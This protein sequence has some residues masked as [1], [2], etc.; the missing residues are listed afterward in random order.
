VEFLS[1]ASSYRILIPKDTTGFTIQNCKIQKEELGA[2]ASK[3]MCLTAD[4]VEKVVLSVLTENNVKLNLGVNF[5]AELKPTGKYA[6]IIDLE[7]GVIRAR[8]VTNEFA[9]RL[10]IKQKI[11]KVFE[12][13][14]KIGRSLHQRAIDIRGETSSNETENFAKAYIE[15][16][17]KLSAEIDRLTFLTTED[18]KK[19][20]VSCF[21]QT[22]LSYPEIKVPQTAE[23][24]FCD[25]V[26]VAF[27]SLPDEKV[28]QSF[29]QKK[30]QLEEI[31]TQLKA[32]KS[33]EEM[34]KTGYL[35]AQVAPLSTYLRALAK[36]L[37]KR[38]ISFKERSIGLAA[39]R[40]Q[41]YSEIIIEIFD[42]VFNPNK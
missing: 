31:Q 42:A 16:S 38:N 41:Q 32:I 23:M 25:L 4:K 8:F 15:T 9:A 40:L 30:K 24:V 28:R 19:E 5:Q 6:I 3:G 11:L 22:F 20:I 27:Y 14:N 10:I 18:L 29:I 37:Q 33:P 39:P 34:E 1:V 21:Q 12:G 7:E 35:W 17:K 2:K 26:D 13:I 36:E